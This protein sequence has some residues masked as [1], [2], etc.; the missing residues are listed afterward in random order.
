[1]QVHRLV[2]GWFYISDHTG[3]LPFRE[4]TLDTKNGGEAGRLP[5]ATQGQPAFETARHGKSTRI[6]TQTHILLPGQH[7]RV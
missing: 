2:I 6:N 5:Q 7:L 4:N 1:M 3:E